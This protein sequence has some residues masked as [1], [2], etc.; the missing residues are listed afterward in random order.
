VIDSKFIIKYTDALYSTPPE[1]APRYD[2]FRDMFSSGQIE[3]KL[4]LLRELKRYSAAFETGTGVIVGAWFG[5]LGILLRDE[6]PKLGITMLDI[7]PRCEKFV[8]NVIY[9]EPS[10]K[11]ITADMYDYKYCETLIINTSCEH[12]ANLANWTSLLPRNRVVVLQ[13]NNYF[14]GN[15]HVNCVNNEDEFATQCGLTEIWFRGKLT[16]PMYTRFMII[17]LT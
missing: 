15:G 7:D 10:L 8:H 4:W 11:Y 12:I 17:G 3:S 14:S 6:Y 2:E 16:M 9:N 1:L 13:S 5:T